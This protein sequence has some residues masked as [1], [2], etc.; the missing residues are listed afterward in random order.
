[1]HR[2]AISSILILMASST[3]L[4]AE[5]Y[6]E[7]L[8][9]ASPQTNTLA[10]LDIKGA[11]SS[12]LA[13]REQWLEK[14]Q[15]NNR[16]GLGFITSD[17]EKVVIAAEVNL[18]TL[19]RDF[20][21]G[22]VKMHNVPSMRELA[23]REGGTNDEIA[24]KLAVLSPRNVYFTQMTASVLAAVYPADRQYTSRWIKSNKDVKTP[25]LSPYLTKAAAK[26][27]D[28][29]VTIA[30]DLED[31]VDRNILKRSLPTSPVVVKNGIKDIGLLANFL[32]SIKGMT[33]AAK[34]DES[35]KG[36]LTVEF[37]YDPTQYRKMLPDLLRELLDGQGV[38]IS[39]L[40]IWEPSFTE[41]TM[42]LSGSM[43]SMD[44]RRVVSL[45]AFPSASVES[46]DATKE[47]Q[48]SLQATRSY[49]SAVDS[50]AE[51]IRKMKDSP[52]YEKTATWHDKAAAQIEHLSRNRVD[53]IAVDAAI[54]VARRLHAI[55]DSLR[56]VPI[57][58]DDLASQAYYYSSPSIGMMP[59]GWWGWKPVVL[60]PSQVD[61]NIPQIQAAIS[62]V[63]SDDQERRAET[64]SQI[65]RIIVEARRKLSE[66]Y[67]SDF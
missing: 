15:P 42:T 56:G 31:V 18:N 4:A 7:L 35:I 14:G 26:A 25:R 30:M 67:K 40:D 20:Q 64:L 19:V 58:A 16:A 62:K 5:P 2:L 17:A 66:K 45:F 50:I 54:Q 34:V 43:T 13:K 12:S 41:T 51:S 61:T 38:W 10:L 55:A 49:I 24:G 6:E 3:V 29:T 57:N 39:E 32:A 27:G 1:M 21:V 59:G 53:P 44:L 8:K 36:S 28:N 52:K 11:F 22:L 23:A 33:F 47:G 9:Y 65:A 63:I 37:V 60:G 48:Y 46:P